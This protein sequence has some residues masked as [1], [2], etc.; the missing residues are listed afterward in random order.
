MTEY[1]IREKDKQYLKVIEGIPKDITYRHLSNMFFLASIPILGNLVSFIMGI[2]C[3]WKG[4]R[5]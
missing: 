5:I 3:R 4:K 2:E 1:K